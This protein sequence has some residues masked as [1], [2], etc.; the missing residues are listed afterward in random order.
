[1]KSIFRYAIFVLCFACNE[2]DDVEDTDEPETKHTD[3]DEYEGCDE[4]TIDARGPDQ[5]VVGD[6]WTVWLKCDGALMQGPMVIRFTPA[7]FATLDENV[8][9]FTTA[10]EASMRVQVGGYR[11]DMDVT[12]LAE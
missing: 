5:P 9:T 3:T 1:M 4:T 12:V 6:E 8:V 7:D 2:K 11:E 10:G